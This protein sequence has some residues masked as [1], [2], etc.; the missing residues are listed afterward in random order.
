[1]NRQEAIANKRAQI[2]KMYRRIYDKAV[3]GRSRRAAITLSCLEC[4]GYQRN[5]VA[6]CTSPACPLW[7]F[8]P[9]RL[10]AGIPQTPEKRR[11][12]RAESTNSERKE[13]ITLSAQVDQ[14]GGE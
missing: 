1:M 4:M 12:N 9:Y 3:S 11:D 13:P 2:P 10:P 14:K 7:V 6:A 8:R 5:Q